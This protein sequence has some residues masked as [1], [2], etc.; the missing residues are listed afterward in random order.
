MKFADLIQLRQSD[1]RYDPKPVDRSLI[2]QCIDAARFAP[3][4]NNSQP[5]FFIVVDDPELKIKIARTTSDPVINF[6]KFTIQAPVIVVM[7][8]R[9]PDL[10]T[11]IASGIKKRDWSQID[12]GIA[13]AHFCLQATEL[14][15]GTCMIG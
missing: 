5:W 15:L 7:L 2:T 8:S 1:R 3:S 11:R 14:G 13:A 4:A 12:A 6:N 9:K 10:V